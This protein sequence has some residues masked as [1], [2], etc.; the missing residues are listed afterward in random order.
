MEPGR[1]RD[2]TVPLSQ[3]IPRDLSGERVPFSM[4]SRRLMP[5]RQCMKR[6]YTT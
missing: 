6:L 4:T 2:S 1:S 5:G 3:A